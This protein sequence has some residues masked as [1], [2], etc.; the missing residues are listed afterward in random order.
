MQAQWT[1]AKASAEIHSSPLWK[2]TPMRRVGVAAVHLGL[3]L[4]AFALA[5]QIRFEGE[6]PPGYASAAGRTV[7]LLLAVRFLAFLALGLFH[8]VWRYAG[9][10]E[11]EKIVLGTTLSSASVFVLER[12]ALG[13]QASRAVFLGEWLASIVLVGG[14]RMLLRSIIERRRRAMG[15]AGIR[16]LIVGA[17]D[18]GESFLRDVQRMKDG[19]CWAVLGFV[20][21]NPARKGASIHGV[22]VLG[23]ASGAT[24]ERLVRG[25]SVELV[26]LAMPT[27]PGRRIRE[28]VSTCRNLGVQVKTLNKLVHQ[29]MSP[30]GAQGVRDIN[31]DDLLQRDPV[32]LDVG[33]IAGMVRDRVVL[34]T[35]AA[36]SI[37]SE[38]CRQVLP[39]GPRRL[40]LVDHDE[41]A[42]FHVDR[43]LRHLSPETSIEP[44]IGDITDAE[45]I[46]QIFALHRPSLILHA[47]AHKHVA[48]M[49][50]NPCEAVKNNVFG[51]AV[52]AEAA[53]AHGA[54]AFVLISTDKAV[55]PSSVMGCTK[56]VAEMI[57]Q[58]FARQSPTRFVAVR[59]GNVLG[60]AGSV[61]PIFR[62]QIARGG[63]VTV[64]HPDVSRYFMTIPEATQLVL[65]AAC[66]GA[67]GEI[68]LLDMGQPVKI[69]DLARDLIELSG[70]RPG[71]D[72][73]VEFTGLKPGEK[74]T[75]ELLLDAEAHDRTLCPKIVIGRI[76]PKDPAVLELGLKHLRA[77]AAAGDQRQAVHHLSLLVPE[78]T[79]R[80]E[81][82]EPPHARPPARRP[83]LD[84]NRETP[85]G[86]APVRSPAKPPTLN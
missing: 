21:D 44:V 75:E 15:G 16:T 79:L 28:L 45:R 61:V 29:V 38:L 17:G 14:V 35:G 19:A 56:R 3:W 83:L 26:V 80:V 4:I 85:V 36:G 49:E 20:D 67:T 13:S 33:Q 82:E 81:A 68:L 27:A 64:T 30:D 69:V 5:M 25:R 58:R 46:N 76:R 51:T 8:G 39:F 1:Q 22:K 12:L 18:A 11:L 47:A 31:I 72:I 10:P 42:L 71:V 74:L 66:L 9:L 2:S 65:Q 59:F 73:E 84:L 57:V 48:M 43:E 77:A 23:N 7:A 40:V 41:N 53:H 32:Q 63:P 55:R 37:G 52:T 86:T 62:E 24:L 34:V 60:S 54:D 70:L 78:A 6:A 50:G